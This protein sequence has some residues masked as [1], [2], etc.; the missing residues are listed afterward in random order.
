MRAELFGGP[1]RPTMLGRYQVRE[2]LGAGGMGV[3]HAAFDPKL[4]RHVALKLLADDRVADVEAQR[5]FRDEGQVMARLSHP[6]VV[7]VFDVGHA[8]GLL[9]IA[10][11]LVQGQT[12]AQW[13]RQPRPVEEIVRVFVAA[14]RGL[15]AAHRAGVVHRDFK[16]HNVLIGVGGRVQ[17]TDFGLARIAVPRSDDALA[18]ASADDQSTTVGQGRSGTPRYM[19]PEQVRGD[20]ID[21]RSDQYAL[22][23][24]LYECLHGHVPGEEPPPG[25]EPIVVPAA[26]SVALRRGLQRDPADRFGSVDALLAAMTHRPRARS[27]AVLGTLAVLVSATV[28]S[29]RSRASWCTAALNRGRAVWTPMRRRAVRAALETRRDA[30][31]ASTVVEQLD[32][33]HDSWTDAYTAACEAVDAGPQPGRS[34]YVTACLDGRSAR[35]EAMLAVLEDPQTPRIDGVV[36]WIEGQSSTTPCVQ[37]TAEAERWEPAPGAPD[38][39][40]AAVRAAAARIEALAVA[41]RYQDARVAGAAAVEQARALGR[42]IVLAHVLS[43]HARVCSLTD[44][45]E[46]AGEAFEEAATLATAHGRDALAAAV[47]ISA[48]SLATGLGELDVARERIR[49]AAAALHRADAGDVERAALLAAEGNVAALAGD[50]P[51]AVAAFRQALARRPHDQ[52]LW[53]AGVRLVLAQALSDLGF[54]AEAHAAHREALEAFR[55]RL[56][57]EHPSIADCTNALGKLLIKAGRHAEAIPL[58]ERALAKL[59]A[60]VGHRHMS[61]AVALLRLGQALSEQGQHARAVELSERGAAIFEEVRG[62]DGM[63]VEVG[64]ARAMFAAA[65][66]RAGQI[67]RAWAPARS[68]LR[69]ASATTDGDHSTV[70]SA[71]TLIGALDVARGD[72]AAAVVSLNRALAILRALPPGNDQLLASALAHAARAHLGLGE[73]STAIAQ[74]HASLVLVAARGEQGNAALRP[75][76]TLSAAELERGDAE[77]A[78]WYAARAQARGQVDDVSAQWRGEA[79]YAQ[80]RAQW[81]A[82]HPRQAHRLADQAL[83]RLGPQGQPHSVQRIR[84]WIADHPK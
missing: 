56:G 31:S 28:W 25:R 62:G 55:E 1:Q 57:D 32:H 44:D 26:V 71:L 2:R 20:G 69:I 19:A 73:V 30:A 21:A 70:A 43:D 39:A 60:T 24:A 35:L 5:R 46:G 63:A 76:L 80:A 3:V 17:V 13:A 59:E 61:T 47:W 75:L 64:M 33:A 58:V 48:I 83:R 10:M 51:R 79:D 7:P 23:V 36:A 34:E 14:G 27:V 29:E 84:E 38:P 72:H 49:F 54:H 50:R 67:E 11:E 9:F 8:R 65:L 77:A 4:E 6:N 66:L 68:A 81:A 15:A 22:C 52:E 45:T 78:A 40:V 37:D 18:I 42:P 74:A 12:L 82:G 41:G 16:P 53:G